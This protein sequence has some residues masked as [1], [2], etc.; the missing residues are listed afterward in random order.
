MISVAWTLLRPFLPYLIMCV[1]AGAAWVW[2]D[3]RCNSACERRNDTIQKLQAELGQEIAQRVQADRRADT[4][5]MMYDAQGIA[6]EKQLKQDRENHDAALAR[7]DVQIKALRARN[8]ALSRDLVSVWERAS[9]AANEAAG[10]APASQGSDGA[11][12]PVSG[13]AESHSIITVSEHSLAVFVKD[14]SA[15][16]GVCAA[17][18]R[19]CTAMY[20]SARDAQLT[21]GERDGQ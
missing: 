15:A 12:A 16:Y 7:L 14:A 4:L 2:A 11:T 20:N 6:A 9:A 8:V 13:A 18:L 3:Q 21:T 5:Q 10:H 19:T 1:V 17:R